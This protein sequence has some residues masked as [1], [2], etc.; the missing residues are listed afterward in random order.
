MPQKDSVSHNASQGLSSWM[1]LSS[2]NARDMGSG[3]HRNQEGGGGEF[4]DK[5]RLLCHAVETTTGAA[6]AVLRL[7][8]TPYCTGDLKS[9]GQGQP[10]TPHL[11]KVEEA[12]CVKNADQ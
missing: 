3:L 7:L 6:N 10:T 12:A 4:L 2:G 5:H 8:K 1:C 11:H 9:C